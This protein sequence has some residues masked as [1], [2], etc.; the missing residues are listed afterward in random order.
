LRMDGCVTSTRR[1]SGG[2]VVYCQRSDERQHE[3]IRCLTPI[4]PERGLN[5]PRQLLPMA[6]ITAQRRRFGPGREQQIRSVLYQLSRC[7]GA[8]RG[9]GSCGEERRCDKGAGR[10]DGATVNLIVGKVIPTRAFGQPCLGRSRTPA[11]G[12]L[13]LV[14]PFVNGLGRGQSSDR[15]TGIAIGPATRRR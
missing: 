1:Q 14:S 9:R 11:C 15:L 13:T 10:A 4:P 6:L 5:G 12:S 8:D 3:S 2:A 7:G